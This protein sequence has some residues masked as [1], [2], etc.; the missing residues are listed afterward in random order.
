VKRVLALVV[1]LVF[2]GGLV[3][4]CALGSKTPRAG[5]NLTLAE[6][7]AKAE[8]EQVYQQMAAAV[9]RKDVNALVTHYSPSYTIIT[10]SGKT[11]N[12]EQ[13]RTSM[14]ADFATLTAITYSSEIEDLTLTGDKAV[15]TV[16]QHSERTRFNPILQRE[17]IRKQDSRSE[18]TWVK[19]G[20]QWLVQSE[21]SL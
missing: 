16:R 9:E 11:V 15:V 21:K 18:D 1:E 13:A 8:I 20:G 4:G 14:Q 17:D 5:R 2:L 6:Q 7:T 19:S 3:L 10:S 12:L